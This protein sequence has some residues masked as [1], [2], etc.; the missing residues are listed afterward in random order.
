MILPVYLYGQPVL[1]KIAQN[2][3]KDYP[4]LEKF[5]EDMFETMYQSDGVGLAAPQIGRAIRLF[6][7]DGEPMS[8]DDETLK[9][10]K[11]VF[12]NAEIYEKSGEEWY[13]NEGCLSVPGIR[14]DVLRK[15]EIKIKYLDENFVEHDETYKGIAARIIQHE[16][17]HLEGKLIPDRLP[18]LRRT[19]LKGKLASIAKG[20]VNV[21]YKFK[22]PR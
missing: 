1:K 11:K 12:I 19:M 15:S 13:F 8:D 4:E 17:D 2:I 10:F 14:E 7:I 6:V 5:I 22:V 16:Y 9:G 3:N 20:K 18:V 21:N